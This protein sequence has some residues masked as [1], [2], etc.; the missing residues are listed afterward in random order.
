[1]LLKIVFNKLITKVN[2]IGTKV[3]NN[4]ELDSKTQYDSEKHNL[5]KKIDDIG[6]KISNTNNLVTKTAFNT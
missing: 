5:E 2:A 3:P 6:K 4:G 1:M